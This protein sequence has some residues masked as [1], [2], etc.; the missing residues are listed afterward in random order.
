MVKTSTEDPVKL[1][2]E[3]IVSKL[4]GM[5]SNTNIQDEGKYNN[6]LSMDAKSYH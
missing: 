2:E 3:K 6:L 4:M 5:S 1:I